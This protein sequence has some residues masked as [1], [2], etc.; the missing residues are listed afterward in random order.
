MWM[1]TDLPIDM[2][3]AVVR[4]QCNTILFSRR[5]GVRGEECDPGVRLPRWCR[6]RGSLLQRLILAAA[7]AWREHTRKPLAWLHLRL[8][9]RAMLVDFVAQAISRSQA[10]DVLIRCRGAHRNLVAAYTADPLGCHGL[11][12]PNAFYQMTSRTF[13][14]HSFH[15]SCKPR[16]AAL[17]PIRPEHHL[18]LRPVALQHPTKL[19]VPLYFDESE[20]NKRLDK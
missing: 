18:P 7:A 13:I 14:L 2:A 15:R 4:P 12:L 10:R 9:S 3:L 16:A 6:L 19:W 8:G 5:I 1:R 11:L 17:A 20:G